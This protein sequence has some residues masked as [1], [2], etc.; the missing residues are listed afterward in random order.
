VKSAIRRTLFLA[1]ALLLL[2]P[3]ALPIRWSLADVIGTTY[4]SP[5]FGYTVTWP[6]TWYFVDE[7]TTDGVDYLWIASGVSRAQYFGG[8]ALG[9]PQQELAGMIG[10][11][12][13]S[14]GITGFAPMLDAQ[15]A[16]LR[17]S[18]GDSAYAYYTFTADIGGGQYL[19]IVARLEVISIRAGISVA[20]S[21]D[22]TLAE[23]QA[24]PA[25]FDEVINGLSTGEALQ[26]DP[27]PG[28]DT[29]PVPDTD[30]TVQETT[31]LD[32]TSAEP[33]PVVVSGPWR[34]AIV[35]TTIGAAIPSLELEPKDGREWVAVFADITNWSA[36]GGAFSLR[37]PLVQTAEMTEPW[38]I[39]PSS[40]R[41]VARLL[42]LG[43]QGN[44]SV[45]IAAETTTRVV[46]VYSIPASGTDARLLIGD[47]ALPLDEHFDLAFDPAA[48]PAQPET[49][50][51]LQGTLTTIS[52]DSAGAV[53]F[54]VDSSA[55]AYVLIGVDLPSGA[56]CF[57]A[58]SEAA[59][60]PHIGMPVLVETDPAVAQP[61]S[62]YLWLVAPDGSRTLLNQDLLASGAA[63]LSTLPN[64]AR[65]ASW[66]Q[67]TEEIAQAA[68][69]GLWAACGA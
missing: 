42:G 63:R 34:L 24:N 50:S 40:T 3:A 61:T 66:L 36:A 39:A 30:A 38:D 35:S 44:D 5:T 25:V 29:I 31:P 41:Q 7:S 4:T 12:G 13:S 45:D 22:T 64:A 69:T 58:E 59:I 56:D 19:D 68:G 67:S 16:P 27:D 2:A 26:P 20:A 15:G 62:V 65:F 14:P 55:E 1:V 17:G 23:F 52:I 54:D 57:A 18:D 32:T 28:P 9:T 53:T 46:L 49:P 60:I 21:Y 33:A 48:L 10:G 37:D 6:A 8:P 47:T 43:E 11:W 51:V